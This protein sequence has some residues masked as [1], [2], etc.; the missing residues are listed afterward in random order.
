MPLASKVGSVSSGVSYLNPTYL[1]FAMSTHGK[2]TFHA[3]S[4]AEGYLQSR[5]HAHLFKLEL[6]RRWVHRRDRIRDLISSL[7]RL[8]LGF[9]LE[10]D[11]HRIRIPIHDP[12]APFL[13]GVDDSDGLQT[14]NDVGS[15]DT[16]FK[17]Y[18]PHTFSSVSR[19]LCTILSAISTAGIRPEYV[20]PV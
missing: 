14:K 10:I 1:F 15:G 12:R 18:A 19:P 6:D 8:F 11:E 4:L 9:T 7:E 17:G 16:A 5:H 20:A 13:C 3:V 2:Y